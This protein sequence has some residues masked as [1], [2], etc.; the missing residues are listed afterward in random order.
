MIVRRRRAETGSVLTL[1][2]VVAVSVGFLLTVLVQKGYVQSKDSRFR[3]ESTRALYEAYGELEIAESI[4]AESEY[5]SEGKNLAIQ[6]ALA[7]PEKRIAGTDVTVAEMTGSS[8]T[9]YSMTVRVPYADHYERVV[10]QPVREIDFF[11]SYNLFVSEDAAGV[12]G[13]PVGAIHSNRDVQFYFPNGD[14]K[15]S[16]T[17]V[18][19][20]SYKAGATE[21]NTSITGPFNPTGERIELDLGSTDRTNL[22]HIATN[23]EADFAYDE[24]IDV[25][26]NFYIV[27]GKQWVEVEKWSQPATNEIT[28]DVIVGYDLVNPREETYTYTE[29]VSAG[30][31]TRT[32]E[33]EVFD[34]YETVLVDVDE[35]VY[36]TDTRVVQ[37][38]VYV[39]EVKTREVPVYRDEER[40]RTVTQQVWVTL[41]GDGSGGAGGTTV[42]GDGTVG[43]WAEQE[44]E[45]TYTVQVVDHYETESYTEKVFSH[46]EDVTETY[47]RFDHYVTVSEEQEQPVYRTETETYE[48][49]LFETVE[50]TGTET[51]YDE[52]PVYESQTRTEYAPSVLLSTENLAVADNGLIHAYGDV[53][54]V[55]GEVID[56][57]TVASRGSILVTGNVIYKDVD[58]DSAYLNGDKPWLS[59]EANVDYDNRATLGLVA[60]KDVLFTRDVPDNF[61]I[62]ASMLAITGRV[63]VDGIVLDADGNVAQ[64]NYF[65]DEFG[66]QEVGATFNKNSIRRLGG[67]TTARRP[68]ETV[69]DDSSIAA[70][71]NVGN[72]VFDIGLLD[73]PPPFFLTYNSPRFFATTIVK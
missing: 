51:V 13:A 9:W 23:A 44:V 5:S 50:R 48:V 71:F 59:Y 43:Y 15:H 10:T 28:E 6:A 42:A 18:E 40:T 8:G 57:V 61:E 41:D 69:L 70:G 53:R 30:F 37:E 72:A 39:D 65:T 62:N 68:V 63:G 38:A 46:Y 32:R 34:H 33:I 49:E 64:Y 4:I 24:T 45:E 36:V 55:S 7:H 2:I 52:E 56:R 67:M 26:L 11:S 73:G 25:G 58:G 20:H 21:D 12:S 35:P 22:D 14:F 27:D 16:V 1:V 66:R 47:E 19:G 60:Y 31:E 17:A 54:A 3:I 29:E